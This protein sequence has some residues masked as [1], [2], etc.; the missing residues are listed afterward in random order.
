MSGNSFKKIK[1]YS[2]DENARLIEAVSYL[3]PPFEEITKKYGKWDAHGCWRLSKYK[4]IYA[5]LQG[6]Q[7]GIFDTI[8]A[9]RV[10]T[11]KQWD[12]ALAF[13]KVLMTAFLNNESVYLEFTE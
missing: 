10:V 3:S 6:F 11:D 7:E 8:E 9:N 1:I 12:T 5:I 4:D 2:Y 13:H